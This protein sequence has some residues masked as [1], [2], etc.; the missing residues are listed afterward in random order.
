MAK[1]EKKQ[2]KTEQVKK[3]TR[4]I[5]PQYDEMFQ[6]WDLVNDKIITVDVFKQPTFNNC[7]PTDG[8]NFLI[9]PKMQRL[10]VTTKG[11]IDHIESN[12]NKFPDQDVGY[13]TVYKIMYQEGYNNNQINVSATKTQTDGTGELCPVETIVDSYNLIR[14]SLKINA[15]LGNNNEIYALLFN[16]SKFEFKYVAANSFEASFTNFIL[17]TQ[18]KE[19]ELITLNFKDGNPYT[20]RLVVN[21]SSLDGV[22]DVLI[23]KGFNRYGYALRLGRNTP[24]MLIQT[25]AGLCTSKIVA[26][27]MTNKGTELRQMFNGFTSPPIQPGMSNGFYPN[28]S[29]YSSY[30]G[31]QSPFP[32]REYTRDEFQTMVD[33][34]RQAVDA[35]VD[36]D[37]LDMAIVLGSCENPHNEN[38]GNFW[39]ATHPTLPEFTAKE[40][41]AFDAK[42]KVKDVLREIGL[43][44][45]LMHNTTYGIFDP[46]QSENE[47]EEYED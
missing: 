28:V 2:A 44:R 5:S 8:N 13:G 7:P 30:G 36:S 11:M 9:E 15:I 40:W 12:G 10:L 42:K 3:S 35:V 45:A 37:E 39:T 26:T 32:K 38:L 41:T 33:R 29:P 18:Y 16:M 31:N 27:L 14:P 47:D 22:K 4:V 24:D 21:D 19:E 43:A 25:A 17:R 6:G 1:P 34:Y 20:Y 23:E 46:A